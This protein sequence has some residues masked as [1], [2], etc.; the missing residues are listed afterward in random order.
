MLYH[1]YKTKQ[2]DLVHLN[3]NWNSVSMICVNEIECIVTPTLY[4][5]ILT[6]LLYTIITKKKYYYN[7]V[8][9]C[10]TYSHYQVC[11]CVTS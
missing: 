5:L 9:I 6:A 10:F 3:G 2:H 4:V 7:N 11:A 1:V 8:F